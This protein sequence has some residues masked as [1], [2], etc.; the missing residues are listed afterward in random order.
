M[1][2]LIC[3]NPGPKAVGGASGPRGIAKVL[4]DS[5]TDGVGGGAIVGLA[6]MMVHVGCRPVLGWVGGGVVVA[7]P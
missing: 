7:I 1:G 6:G 4:G 2:G 3:R 5:G